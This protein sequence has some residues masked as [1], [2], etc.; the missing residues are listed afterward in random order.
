MKTFSA[1]FFNSM[2]KIPF[3]EDAEPVSI[4]FSIIY[5]RHQSGEPKNTI[6]IKYQKNN[7][8]E[9]KLLIQSPKNALLRDIDLSTL[10]STRIGGKKIYRDYNN[11]FSDFLPRNLLYQFSYDL[12]T[13]VTDEDVITMATYRKENIKSFR[14]NRF[15]KF[16]HKILEYVKKLPDKIND[17]EKCSVVFNKEI[18][19]EH[20]TMLFLN[21]EQKTEI[22][23]EIFEDEENTIRELASDAIV[24]KKKIDNFLTE[25]NTGKGDIIFYKLNKNRLLVTRCVKGNKNLLISFTKELIQ[26][27]K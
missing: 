1:E 8:E 19:K 10:R 21:I 15:I 25:G 5:P 6:M 9:L 12:Y 20:L 22:M 7:L 24:S 11:S 3:I 2:K 23:T 27:L 26:K 17:F 13:L 14:T 4:A 18:Y 16:K